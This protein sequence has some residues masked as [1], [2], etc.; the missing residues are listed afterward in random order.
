[1]TST[2]AV[3]GN[4]IAALL[5]G[6]GIIAALADDQY[7]FICLPYTTA[8]IGSHFRHIIDHYQCLLA[9]LAE[10]RVDYD[11]RDRN[12]LI[13]RHTG[14][15]LQ[16]LDTTV[17]AMRTLQDES[18]TGPQLSLSVRLC[19]TLSGVEDDFFPSTLHREMVF[20]HTHTTHHFSLVA[21]LMRLID[22]PVDEN[23]G[24]APS[25]LAYREQSRCA[26]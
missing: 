11:V 9:G 26:R 18:V 21:L 20:L 6:R 3:I 22:L 23:L 15:A 19:T 24:V 7:S 4:N 13:E 2:N 25:T 5:T 1:M 8:S 14:H 10:R 16:Q 17:A 12:I